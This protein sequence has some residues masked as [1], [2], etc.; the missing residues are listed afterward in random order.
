MRV[1]VHPVVN[2]QTEQGNQPQYDEQSGYVKRTHKPTLLDSDYTLRKAGKKGAGLI[3]TIEEKDFNAEARSRG[4][5]QG[6]K[7]KRGS[8][9]EA[10]LAPARGGARRK[11]ENKNHK[12]E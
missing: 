9:Q 10:A 8:E 4:E 5:R 7:T 11:A 12:R 2:T 3:Q 6:T 1:V